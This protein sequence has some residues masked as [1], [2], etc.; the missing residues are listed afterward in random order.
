MAKKRDRLIIKD[1][2]IIL[3]KY[4]NI[5]I[6]LHV[7]VTKLACQVTFEDSLRLVF[8]SEIKKVLSP[9]ELQQINK[10]R[11]LSS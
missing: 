11:N 2:D 5:G 6:V 3:T 1:N 4:N 9:K 8:L 7:Y 10:E